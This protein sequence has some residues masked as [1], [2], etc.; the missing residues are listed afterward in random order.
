M[1]VYE[2]V[3]RHIDKQ[4]LSVKEVAEAAG[5]PAAV[6]REILR[7]HRKLYPEDLKAICHALNTPVVLFIDE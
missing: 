5:I 6:L 4:G 3:R 7:G 2:K 1:R